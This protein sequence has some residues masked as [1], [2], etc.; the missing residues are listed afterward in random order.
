MESLLNKSLRKTDEY[1]EELRKAYRILPKVDEDG[2]S[3]CSFAEQL[4]FQKQESE[5]QLQQQ[6]ERLKADLAEINAKIKKCKSNEGIIASDQDQLHGQDA[7]DQYEEAQ[8]KLKTRLKQLREKRTHIKSKNKDVEELLGKTCKKIWP[9]GDPEERGASC[10]PSS[11]SPEN[12]MPPD[13]RQLSTD[14]QLNGLFEIDRMR[15]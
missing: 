14:Q 7:L 3:K 13:N 10:V 9:D 12:S 6:N 5:Q 4:Y 11:A 15:Y 2:Y 1:M 8:N